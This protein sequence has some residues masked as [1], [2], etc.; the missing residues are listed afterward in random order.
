MRCVVND[1]AFEWDVQKN[2]VDKEKHGIDFDP[3][4]ALWLDE[5]RAEVEIRFPDE[6]DGLS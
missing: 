1:M 5:A 6:K 4:R 2:R 3:A